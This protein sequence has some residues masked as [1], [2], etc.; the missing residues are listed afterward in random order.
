MLDLPVGALV[1]NGALQDMPAVQAALS[2]L[3][4]RGE[5]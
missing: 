5:D 4:D 3:R 1:G 2:W